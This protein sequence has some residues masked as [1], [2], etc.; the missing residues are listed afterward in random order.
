MKRIDIGLPNNS[1]C[2][3]PTPTSTHFQ[4]FLRACAC[5][6]NV[7][8]PCRWWAGRVNVDVTTITHVTCQRAQSA[9][10]I[11]Y[12][13]PSHSF[14]TLHY[15]CKQKTPG[16]S[17]PKHIRIQP[18]RKS[19]P[20]NRPIDRPTCEKNPW[21]CYST[22]LQMSGTDRSN[23]ISYSLSVCR[24]LAHLVVRLVALKRLPVNTP[25]LK[26]VVMAP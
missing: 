23:N 6:L 8:R 26:L 5:V 1:Y 20:T 15:A 21:A 13:L 25:R 12:L 16:F 2:P 7:C 4:H 10:C 17:P 18:D 24:S 3:T 11:D 9:V 22:C 14:T 19:R